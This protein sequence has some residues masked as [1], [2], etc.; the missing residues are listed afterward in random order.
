MRPKVFNF[1]SATL[2]CPACGGDRIVEARRWEIHDFLL[3]PLLFL[4]PFRCEECRYRFYGFIFRK[5]RAAPH[6][7]DSA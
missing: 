6:T 5:P 3:L 2:A 4:R 1:E 7:P